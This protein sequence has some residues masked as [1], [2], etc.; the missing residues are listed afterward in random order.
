MSSRWTYAIGTVALLTVFGW[1]VVDL[2]SLYA[3]RGTTFGEGS[4]YRSDEVGTRAFYL[5]LEEYPQKYIVERIKTDSIGDR[6]A[7]AAFVVAEE[8]DWDLNFSTTP[9]EEDPVAEWENW[10]KRGGR[11]VIFTRNCDFSFAG[12][13]VEVS[14]SEPLKEEFNDEE[15]QTHF[16]TGT[17]REYE[18]INA[19]FISEEIGLNIQD[20]ETFLTGPDG[21]VGM[22]VDVGKGQL[23]VIAD[24]YPISNKGLALTNDGYPGNLDL[25]F[26]LATMPGEGP[27]CVYFFET[28]H[29]V[30]EKTTVMGLARR[31]SLHFFLFQLAFVAILGIWGIRMRLGRP[32]SRPEPPVTREAEFA[33]SVA[34]L[35]REAMPRAAILNSLLSELTE[36]AGITARIRPSIEPHTFSA[37][38]IKA[39]MSQRRS[40]EIAKLYRDYLT[41][42]KA[43]ALQMLHFS[44]VLHKAMEELDEQR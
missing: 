6:P 5:L 38:L 25:A 34:A 20:G 12:L 24:T 35:Y 44:T 21:P 18:H 13:D 31:Y 19:N 1:L 23:I 33:R 42:P 15:P 43:S 14:A 26:T 37:I 41:D 39:G 9:S 4:S 28:L 30:S 7:G 32:V 3:G 22:R 40:T 27:S 11:L 8:F 2:L 16:V 36:R 17:T 29:G 10:V